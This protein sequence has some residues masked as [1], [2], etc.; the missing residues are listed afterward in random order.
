[1]SIGAL[2]GLLVRGQTKVKSPRCAGELKRGRS[3]SGQSTQADLSP[4]PKGAK[5]SPKCGHLCP[6]LPFGGPRDLLS[7]AQDSDTMFLQPSF[8]KSRYCHVFVDV[9]A[10]SQRQDS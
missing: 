10:G 4:T 3:D 1:M 5:G 8:T 9:I 2:A 7:P 6:G